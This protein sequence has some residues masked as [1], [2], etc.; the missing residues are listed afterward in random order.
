MGQLSLKFMLSRVV[1]F[2]CNE[3]EYSEVVADGM[4]ECRSGDSC[5]II[6]CRNYHH[7]ASSY[8]GR[9][10]H[11]GRSDQLESGR[12]RECGGDR[13]AGSTD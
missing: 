11:D 5:T 8:R 9:R 13:R 2:L 3:I 12:S 10:G 4:V 1:R 7:C 6:G